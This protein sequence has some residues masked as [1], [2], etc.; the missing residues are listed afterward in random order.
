MESHGR[1]RGPKRTC[2]LQIVKECM[3]FGLR[4]EGV[5]CQSRWYELVMKVSRMLW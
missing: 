4:K 1:K 5:V 2:M 3:R